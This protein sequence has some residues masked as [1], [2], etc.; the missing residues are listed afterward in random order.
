MKLSE[1]PFERYAAITIVAAGAIFL[2]R[3][4]LWPI[5]LSA[6]PFLLAWVLAYLM[7][8]LALRL[9]RRLRLP[10]GPTCVVLVFLSLGLCGVGLFFLLRRAI[11]ELGSLAARLAGDSGW[12]EGFLTGMQDWWEGLVTRFPF[13][14]SLGLG[15]DGPLS[16]L[17]SGMLERV[18]GSL[19]EFATRAAGELVAALPVWLIFVLVSLVS[20]F[21]FALDLGGIHRAVLSFLP[22][23]VRNFMIRVKEGA[24]DTAIGYL[25]AYLLLMFITFLFL[26]AGFL[27]LGV[28]YALLLA[29]LFAVLDFLPVIGVGTLLIPWSVIAF[30]SGDTYT[31]AGLL[32]LYGVITVA[33]Q[34]LEP[35]IVGHHLG[36]HPLLALVSMYAGLQLFGFLGLM[37]L[38]SILLTLRNLYAGKDADSDR[39]TGKDTDRG[40][41]SEDRTGKESRRVQQGSIP[42]GN[43]PSAT[44]FG[45]RREARR[46]E[47]PDPGNG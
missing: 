8:P 34:F 5:L 23:R 37:L 43:A 21:Y 33:R 7:R 20:A 10:L 19:G 38:P 3:L 28:R 22:E 32:I 18:L 6:L 40:D 25:R 14:S 24:W 26:V 30:F 11:L 4:Y 35:R 16:G 45:L 27:V 12:L 46:S 1:I 17:F 15:G 31:G 41:R 44:R 36:M 29:A 13:L 9:H 42:P 39:D 47:P 2:L